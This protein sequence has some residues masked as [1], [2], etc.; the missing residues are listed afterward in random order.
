[1]KPIH[2]AAQEGKEEVIAYLIK[3]GVKVDES[4]IF[5]GTPLYYACINNNI[6]V[7][8]LLLKKWS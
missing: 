3:N 7:A 8:R 4:D 5:G 1:M 6:Q 2:Y